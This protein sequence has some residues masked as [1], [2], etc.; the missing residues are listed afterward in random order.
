[1]NSVGQ[2]LEYGIQA[3]QTYTNLDSMNRTIFTNQPTNMSLI[4]F[5]V[6][7]MTSVSGTVQSQSGGVGVE[8]V[9]VSYCHIDVSTGQPDTNPLYCPIATFVT[10]ILGQYNGTFQ[11][12]N[13]NWVST[14]EN[15]YIT[16]FYNQ[17]V[18]DKN[19]IVHSFSPSQQ[20]TLYHLGNSNTII[21]DT[22]TISIFGS[23][24]FDPSNMGGG[25]YFCPFSNVPVVIETSNG[26]AVNLYSDS[27][28]LFNYSI[29]PMETVTVY[30]PSYNG[31]QWRST[32][33]VATTNSVDISN[34]SKVYTY[35]DSNSLTLIH[36][37]E[38]DANEIDGEWVK[39]L[40]RV[41]NQV[42]INAGE[43][44]LN[45]LFQ[46]YCTGNVKYVINGKT[47]NYY[48]RL[49]YK[50]V[51]DFYNNF[52]NTW[53]NQNNT[54]NH[55]FKMYSTY[56]DLLADINGWQ[57]CDYNMP[58]IGYPANCGKSGYVPNLWSGY[59]P[60]SPASIPQSTEIWLQVFPSSKPYYKDLMTNGDFEVY[61]NTVNTYA[62]PVG[63]QL[64]KQT[65]LPIVATIYTLQGQ[66]PALN[67][68][69]LTFE[70]GSHCGV[71]HALT[72]KPAGNHF[73]IGLSQMIHV[74]A[75]HRIQLEVAVRSTK[76]ISGV[77]VFVNT[78]SVIKINAGALWTRY[79]FKIPASFNDY[80]ANITFTGFIPAYTRTSS[81][82][83][84]ICQVSEECHVELDCIHAYVIP[85]SNVNPISTSRRLQTS[86]S[87]SNKPSTKPSFLP[88]KVPVTAFPTATKQ[89][90]MVPSKTP[91]SLPSSLK[92]TGIPTTVPIRFPT[93]IPS[94]SP[95]STPIT[96][97]PSIQPSTNPTVILSKLPSSTPITSKPSIQPS[98]LPSSTPITSKPSIQPSTKPTMIP[99]KLPSSAPVTSKPTTQPSTNPTMIPSQTPT[100]APIKGCNSFIDF[101][102]ATSS[103][104]ITSTGS[105]RKIFF[106]RTENSVNFC[107]YSLSPANS[108]NAY[109]WQVAYFNTLYN[110]GIGIL[111]CPYHD[112][113]PGYM[114]QI[115]VTN[116][117]NLGD[118]RFSMISTPTTSTGTSFYSV[119]GSNIAGFQGS[120]LLFSSSTLNLLMSL[121]GVQT[122]KY[123][124]IISYSTDGIYLPSGLLLQSLQVVAPC[125]PTYTPSSAPSLIPT[126]FPSTLAPSKPTF[127]PTF[128][129]TG[130]P[131]SRPITFVPSYKPSSPTYVP[132][133]TPS[134]P[135]QTPTT[136][137]LYIYET[138]SER[139]SFAY[140]VLM[141]Q[142]QFTGSSPKNI[143]KACQQY[144]T[145]NIQNTTA[146]VCDYVEIN[147]GLAIFTPG[148]N[149]PFIQLMNIVELSD[150]S[151]FTVI[152]WVTLGISN[153]FL[154]SPL[155]SFGNI[156]FPMAEYLDVNST[157][158]TYEPYEPQGCYSEDVLMATMTTQLLPTNNFDNCFN[159]AKKSGYSY[160]AFGTVCRF[161]VFIFLFVYSII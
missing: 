137:Q 155:F 128:K 112:I 54:L 38:N 104:A 27:Q 51:F 61:S 3:T 48:K 12:A 95:S 131:T 31:N 118:P 28:G 18:D 80:E 59:E 107:A 16:P 24:Q 142:F 105:C 115:D 6:P 140:P 93:M 135:T 119:Y 88:S 56:S 76:N 29:A 58:G 9:T 99:S 139:Y 156:K 92:P 53:S 52:V 69:A 70:K 113:C 30:I 149:A 75:H 86:Q 7:F 21:Y 89:P 160:F 22:T 42:L 157:Y 150:V 126:A 123:L 45:G 67:G 97:K 55:D 94:K 144:V 120:N 138:S 2:L 47:Y 133:I 43:N 79:I 109:L 141:H 11:V 90:S 154:S 124:S 161:E 33:S 103:G 158:V 64:S 62:T 10:N 40:E 60:N 159:Y 106:P 145:D 108:N 37:F 68:T 152:T 72:I 81:R 39:V 4:Q 136:S 46:Q 91:S 26:N 114:I 35:T 49:T 23:V 44:V 87:P 129:P 34:E 20:M 73:T 1:M 14:S 121:P 100:L 122:Y 84:P 143:S 50:S 63:W 148:T 111:N 130:K 110:G 82:S 66:E 127:T 71:G 134:A 125:S 151:T 147:N 32:V 15:F 74:T 116:M 77:E 5:R 36:G 132:S 17:S 13:I 41:D 101:S 85:A 78:D 153:D 25:S 102:G 57:Y 117:T 65:K 146:A 96:S 8:G 83:H 19:F 98:K